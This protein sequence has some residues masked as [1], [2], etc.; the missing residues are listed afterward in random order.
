MLKIFVFCAS[1]P[2]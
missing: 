1:I 2:V